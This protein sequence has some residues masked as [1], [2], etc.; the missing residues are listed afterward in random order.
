MRSQFLYVTIGTG[1]FTENKRRDLIIS[2]A[3]QMRALFIDP[4]IYFGKN[5]LHTFSDDLL[6]GLGD[7]DLYILH[8]I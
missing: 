2:T 6:L 4:N 5:M 1:N 8:S 7:K 3:S